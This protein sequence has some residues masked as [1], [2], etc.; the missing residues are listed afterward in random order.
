MTL[1]E[2]KPREPLF[3]MHIPK[4]AGM[5]MRLYLQ[6]QYDV[7]DVCPALRWH[8]LL[9]LERELASFRL[10]LGHFRYNLR[11]LLADD[12][13]V[14]VIL[15]DPLRRTVSALQNLPPD[16]DFNLDPP[17]ARGLSLSEMIRDPVLMGSQSNVQAR[18]LCASNPPNE[19]SA[20]LERELPQ[21][22]NA[23][24][25]DREP[26]PRLQLAQD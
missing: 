6:E 14:L 15:R 13:R 17:L 11:Q 10:V 24:A 12:A 26:P 19:L 20:Y 23:D 3:F 22:P 1:F 8:G 7:H 2:I 5:S 25:G 4:T 9:G 21:N 16:P 18:F